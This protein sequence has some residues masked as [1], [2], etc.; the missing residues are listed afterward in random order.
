[1]MRDFREILK[2]KGQCEELEDARDKVHEKMDGA[3]YTGTGGSKSGGGGG[4][5]LE[6]ALESFMEEEGY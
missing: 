6:E 1:M 5:G 3:G 2:I 4:L